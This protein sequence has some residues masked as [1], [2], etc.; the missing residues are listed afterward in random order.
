MLFN[1]VFAQVQFFILQCQSILIV[2]ISLEA[3][4]REASQNYIYGLHLIFKERTL[5]RLT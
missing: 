5:P 1:S 4:L 3:F 2:A